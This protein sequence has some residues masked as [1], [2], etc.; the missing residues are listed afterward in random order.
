M[1]SSN[2]LTLSSFCGSP[3]QA[4]HGWIR[5]ATIWWHRAVLRMQSGRG[6]SRRQYG[7]PPA[8]PRAG[9]LA[10][11]RLPR[12]NLIDFGLSAADLG[13]AGPGRPRRCGGSPRLFSRQRACGD[14]CAPAQASGVWRRHQRPWRV[15]PGAILSECRDNRAIDENAMCRTM[16]I[17]RSGCAAFVQLTPGANNPEPERGQLMWGHCTGVQALTVSCRSFE[18]PLRLRDCLSLDRIRPIHPFHCSSACQSRVTSVLR[19]GRYVS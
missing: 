6:G 16:A 5:D 10:R 3:C 12:L 2:A 18:D 7:I 13:S 9:I 4:G 17:G 19:R 14:R 8:M 11:L 1:K 15:I